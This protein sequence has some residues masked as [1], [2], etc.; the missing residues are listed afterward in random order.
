VATHVAAIA[1]GRQEAEEKLRSSEERYS[2]I[3]DTANGGIWNR[4]LSRRRAGIAEQFDFSASP[5]GRFGTLGHRVHGADAG[6]KWAIC[7]CAWNGDLEW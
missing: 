6:R 3:V 1:I 4:R 7:W 5:E 2:R